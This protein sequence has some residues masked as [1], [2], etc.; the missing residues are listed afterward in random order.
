MAELQ[1]TQGVLGLTFYGVGAI[2][3]AGVYSVLG[4]ATAHAGGSLWLAFALGSVVALLSALSYAELATAVPHAGAEYGFLRRAWPK[5]PQI[6]FLVGTLLLLSAAATAATV[7]LAFA[8]SLQLFVDV[9][10]GVAAAGLLL[11]VGGLAAVGLVASGKVNIVLT[12]AELAGLAVVVWLGMRAPEAPPQPLGQPGGGVI[13][14]TAVVFFVYLGFENIVTMSEE[15]RGGP[16]TIAW[17]LLLSLGLTTLAYVAVALAVVALAP[18]DLLGKSETALSLAAGRASPSAGRFVAWVALASTANTAL[19]TLLAAG[20]IAFAMARDRELPRKL[21]RTT[22]RRGSPWL[23]VAAVLGLSMA[24]LPLGG[25]EATA[26]LA[27]LTSLVAF[28]LVHSAVI[29]LRLREPGLQ[30]PFRLPGTV[31]R[32]P[33]LP[34]LG[35]AAIVPLLLRFDLAEWLIAGSVAL[36]AALLRSRRVRHGPPPTPATPGPQHTA[37]GHG[38]GHA[39]VR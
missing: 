1:R 6:G 5:L 16:R 4:P 14:A 20:R 26:R 27:S 15:V 22:P 36:V 24:L 34:L 2:V 28:G 31:G 38:A 7:S 21:A 32:W 23:G 8:R 30:R 18:P 33:V 29:A 3:G 11:A 12:L 13:V 39:A 10:L 9:P 25:V 17:A 35:L 19:I 37:P